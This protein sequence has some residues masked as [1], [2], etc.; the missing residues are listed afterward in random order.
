MKRIVLFALLFCWLACEDA[1]GPAA[2]RR[3]SG[4][5]DLVSAQVIGPPAER[6]SLVTGVLT[7]NG[8]FT[9]EI[10]WHR[11]TAGSVLPLD[12]V[13]HTGSNH[14]Y[15]IACGGGNTGPAIRASFR[16]D[17]LVTTSGSMF[18]GAE[19]RWVKRAPAT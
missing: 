1:T 11:I 19:L 18:G 5:Y 6:D 12:T 7:L 17:T 14:S 10:R 2:E 4:T 15:G 16:S 13:V 8:T 3:Y 9:S